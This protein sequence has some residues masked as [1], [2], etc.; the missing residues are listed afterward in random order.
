MENLNSR[1]K[2]AQEAR[3]ELERR[4]QRETSALH[5]LLQKLSL[6]CKGH[7]KELD[8]RLAQLRKLLAQNPS[9]ESIEELQSSIEIQLQQHDKLIEKQLKGAQESL[10]SSGK[11][12]QAQRG[13]SDGVRRQLRAVLAQV[14]ESHSSYL[15]LIP[16]FSKINELYE[17][18]FAQ[19]TGEGSGGENELVSVREALLALV[20]EIQ[21]NQS[22]QKKASE[23]KVKVRNAS[24]GKQL[25]ECCV[26]LMQLVIRAIELERQAVETFLLNVNEAL[27]EV[28]QQLEKS[29]ASSQELD[30][31]DRALR[32]QL[33]AQIERL[34][35]DVDS[36]SDLNDLKTSIRVH[37]KE[38][39]AALDQ[40]ERVRANQD[41][42]HASLEAIQ[43]RVSELEQKANVFQAKLSE[44]RKKVFLDALTQ[45]PNRAAFDER[46][47]IEYQRWSRY[48]GA[49]T[50]AILDLDHFKMINDTFGHIAGDRT[51][52]IVA[53]L[54]GKVIRSSDFVARYGGEEFVMIFPEQD[55][56]AIR[57]PLEK[58][59]SRISQLPLKFKD[60]KISVTASI[61]AATFKKG[62]SPEETFERA[63]K[64]LYK[65]KNEGRN[66]IVIEK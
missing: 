21:L 28:H 62:E 38:I 52:Q 1:L 56:N 6:A 37:L 61:G 29:R 30:E 23:L 32:R 12:L 36:A 45:L 41:T 63:D 15:T 44:Q 33:R 25:L 58:L 13:L 54:L 16:L 8:N 57:H 60:S 59:R 49:L 11:K 31:Q 55:E 48:G 10:S 2:Q 53:K 7:N 51:L 39:V 65:A 27:S 17:L 34:G 9:V 66:R 35:L 43:S 20:E 5:R 42:L 47:N 19:A 22:S 14:E 4:Y 50:I 3:Q 24:M 64:A 26:E 46:L 40:G 18:A